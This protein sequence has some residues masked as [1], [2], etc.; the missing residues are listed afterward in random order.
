MY[1]YGYL[2]DFNG[3]LF[4]RR[5]PKR[6]V[7]LPPEPGQTEAEANLLLSKTSKTR[8]VHNSP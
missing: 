3:I 5:A 1:I 7:E 2:M 6:L 4:L 8:T